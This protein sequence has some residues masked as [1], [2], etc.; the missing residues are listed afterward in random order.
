MLRFNFLLLFQ[1][2]FLS[3]SIAQDY[4]WQQRVEYNMDVRLDVKTHKVTGTQKLTYYNNSKDTLEQGVLS[5]LLE[6]ISS[7]AA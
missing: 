6:C 2:S 7:R 4:R 3:A 1:I 5:S